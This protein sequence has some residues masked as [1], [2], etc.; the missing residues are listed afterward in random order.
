MQL[1]RFPAKILQ[2]L[3]FHAGMLQ[4]AGFGTL[5]HF[6]FM[7][8]HNQHVCDH[9]SVLFAA[10]ETSLIA[11]CQLFVEIQPKKSEASSALK[12]GQDDTAKACIREALG[13]LEGL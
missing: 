6:L 12:A 5:I 7:L 4:N 11:S 2:I 9:A 8:H 1:T 3:L 10:P 13:L